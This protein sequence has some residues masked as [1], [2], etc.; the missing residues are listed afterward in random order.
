MGC[1]SQRTRRRAPTRKAAVGRGIVRVADLS[2]NAD[3]Q[4]TAE[5]RTR[6]RVV[7]VR[8]VEWH[9]DPTYTIHHGNGSSLPQATDRPGGTVEHDLHDGGAPPRTRRHR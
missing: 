5:H 7:L 1:P 9:Q 3:G 4:T 8:D 2:T 6:V